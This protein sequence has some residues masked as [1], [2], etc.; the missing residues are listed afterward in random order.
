VRQLAI[1]LLLPAAVLAQD[2]LVATLQTGPIRLSSVDQLGNFYALLE[3][4][5]LRKYSPDG[6][7]MAEHS[8]PS[9]GSVTLLECWNQLKP[10]YYLRGSQSYT[11]MDHHLVSQGSFELDPSFAVDPLLACP[12]NNNTI[13]ILDG[14]DLSLKRVNRMINRVEMEI[15]LPSSSFPA[16]P[17]LLY[18]R[19]Y[20]NMLFLLERA[21]GI[22][23]F[24]ILGKPVKHIEAEGLVSFNFMGEELYYLLGD[25][26][27][28][29][30]LFTGE[31]REV[32][33]KAPA[34][35]AFVSDERI[36]LVAG[37]KVEIVAFDPKK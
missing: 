21:T 14:A 36:F 16:Q 25:R 5:T 34:A 9:A 19:E 27:Q 31:T 24:S 2:Q 20:Q 4:G 3:S 7:V 33:V 6:K 23:V 26:I 28:L 30:D 15:S 17:D 35:S 11:L 18:L 8:L 32:P 29:V 37:D 10:F 13:W 12:G 22:H 1:L